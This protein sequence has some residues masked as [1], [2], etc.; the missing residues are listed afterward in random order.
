ME[1]E[2]CPKCGARFPASRAWA[3]RT[4]TMLFLAP[5]LQD[6]DPRVRCPA[7]GTV[8][9]ATEYRFFGV[10]EPKVLRIGLAIFAVCFVLLGVYILFIY[11]P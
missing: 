4:L 2:E 1:D 6:L 3:N 5:A 10:I 11:A 7:C 9:Q 8:F